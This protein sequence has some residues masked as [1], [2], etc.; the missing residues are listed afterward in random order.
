MCTNMLKS[1]HKF[2]LFLLCILVVSIS[3]STAMD[4]GSNTNP[5][6]CKDQLNGSPPAP[7]WVS[8]GG[9]IPLIIVSLIIF[10]GFAHICEEYCVPAIA[11]L[12]KRN[13][14]SDEVTGSIFI[15]AGLS[16]PPLFCSY[17]GIFTDNSPI[18][19]GK[20][21]SLSLSLFFF[22]ITF[23]ISIIFQLFVFL[24]LN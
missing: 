17:I 18:G 24:F 11:V 7:K 16:T 1:S 2:I 5:H 3:T 15:G 6:Q 19:I 12:C 9:F 4:N 14:I 21:F 23:I 20:S 8:D 10:W 22:S 13:N